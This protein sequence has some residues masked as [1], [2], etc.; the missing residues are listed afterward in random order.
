MSS[1][2]GLV[3]L[4]DLGVD[5][6]PGPWRAW[7]V[8]RGDF[9]AALRAINPSCTITAAIPLGEGEIEREGDRRGLFAP[10]RN[11]RSEKN[12]LRR[13]D[14]VVIGAQ[15]PLVARLL[16][17][18]AMLTTMRAP[19][20]SVTSVR[21][22]F[23]ALVGD[24]ANRRALRAKIEYPEGFAFDAEALVTGEH[25]RIVG[26]VVKQFEALEVT[27]GETYLDRMMRELVENCGL[28][29]EPSELNDSVRR[30][31]QALFLQLLHPAWALESPSPHA[32][33]RII[34]RVEH[35][36]S[37]WLD[38]ILHHPHVRS[39]DLTLRAL[40]RLAGESDFDLVQCSRAELLDPP[41]ALQQAIAALAP[42]V[43]CAMHVLDPRSEAAAL[44]AWIS[45]AAALQ[46]VFLADAP[47]E[48]AG[49]LPEPVPEAWA[50]LARP[51]LVGRFAL[52]PQRRRARLPYD[53][54]SAP[55]RELSYEESVGDQETAYL[56][57]S[58]AA[59]LAPFIAGIP[60]RPGPRL[61]S[62][63][64][65]GGA[66]ALLQ[67]YQDPPEPISV[68]AIFPAPPRGDGA[69]RLALGLVDLRVVIEPGPPDIQAPSGVFQRLPDGRFAATTALPILP[70][71]YTN[72]D[73]HR[74]AF[75]R[76]GKHACLRC[77]QS[78][79]ESPRVAG[80]R[81]DGTVYG[82]THFRCNCGWSTSFRFD[83][84][85]DPETPYHFETRWWATETEP[86]SASPPPAP[87]GDPPRN[88]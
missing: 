16:S 51:E 81:A 49:P 28:D 72:D 87:P 86:L 27:K 9:V 75:H 47:I 30:C 53:P 58:A 77:G 67:P 33:T 59:F 13:L 36:L 76:E 42:R 22:L 8:T 52:F 43:L 26:N 50:A 45:R 38:P 39:M 57:A 34:A 5:P 23:V 2:P 35:R 1:S 61:G 64:V 68:L 48:L 15:F 32:L 18:R 65:P 21:K 31:C 19:L 44:R 29:R 84:Q 66:T 60:A 55:V 74:R 10:G 11:N 78:T 82:E 41:P 70:A 62:Q 85:R 17:F 56:G 3:V 80:A 88:G 79:V 4:G 37:R 14:P 40:D 71:T 63:A 54:W 20:G 25:A 73:V 24:E 7:H 46:A 6:G 12:A 69:R 83:G